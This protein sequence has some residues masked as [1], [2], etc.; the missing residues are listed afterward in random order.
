[1][2]R[3]KMP[4]PRRQYTKANQPDDY[5]EY[6]AVED[7]EDYDNDVENYLEDIEA[8]NKRL[9]ELLKTSLNLVNGTVP[10]PEAASIYAEWLAGINDAALD[11]TD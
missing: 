9:R 8:E 7:M 3:P 4:K 5:S 11:V 6:Y 10:I 2:N 1:M